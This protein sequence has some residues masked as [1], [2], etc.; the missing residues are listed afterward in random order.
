MKGVE[1][2]G[3]ESR[4]TNELKPAVIIFACGG[5]LPRKSSGQSHSQVYSFD[6]HRHMVITIPN[7]DMGCIG[8]ERVNLLCVSRLAE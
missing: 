5:K 1:P 4:I 3:V 8:R 7:G 6:E 2:N